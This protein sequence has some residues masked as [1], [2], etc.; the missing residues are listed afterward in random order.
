VSLLDRLFPPDDHPG[1]GI[2]GQVFLKATDPGPERR[3][4]LPPSGTGI[5]RKRHEDP[6]PYAQRIVRHRQPWPHE[7]W[8]GVGQGSGQQYEPWP[9]QPRP[10]GDR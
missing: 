2:F 7:S 5:G 10:G 6:A 9:Y 8:P 4:L 1:V 3:L